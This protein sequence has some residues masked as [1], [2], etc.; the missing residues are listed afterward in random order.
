V[1]RCATREDFRVKKLMMRHSSRYQDKP[2]WDCLLCQQTFY[3]LDVAA[4]HLATHHGVDSFTIC[5]GSGNINEAKSEAN[6]RA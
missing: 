4:A 1:D 6:P 5:L 2:R 3:Y